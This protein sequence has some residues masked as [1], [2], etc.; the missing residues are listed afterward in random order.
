MKIG[1]LTQ[2]INNNY[3]GILQNYALQT[4]LTRMGHEVETLNWDAYRC[5]HADESKG[6]LAWQVIKT[7]ISKSI[8]RRHRN[9]PWQ[10]R[11][12]FY[13]LSAN[14][15]AFCKQYIRQSEWLWGKGQFRDHTIDGH[16]DAL[17]VG[18]DQTW[19]PQYN[20]NGMLYRMFLDFTQGLDIKRIAYA[21][22]FGVDEWEYDEEQ[23]C[24]CSNLLK[25]FHAVSVR[26][27]SGV[28][29]CRQ[30]LHHNQTECVIDPTM[31]LN[32]AD[33][34]QLLPRQRQ[35][36]S[37]GLM[38]TYILDNSSEKQYAIHNIVEKKHLKVVKFAP[39]YCNLG[40]VTDDTIGNYVSPSVIEWL[41][42]IHDADYV[43]C[44]SFHGTVF[45]IIFNKPFI[46]IGNRNRG[47]SRF[48]SLLTQF[49]LED[50]LA[51]PSNDIL[52]TLDKPF[53][54]PMVNACRQAL[55]KRS[56]QFL[57]SALSQ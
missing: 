25:N 57:S 20:R 39:M 43:I 8:L 1:I 45:S 17:L 56:L 49:G 53:D 19:R 6:R 48:L 16:F 41:Q 54:W 18:S 37:T 14:N 13:R 33:Y 31:L 2:S 44:D 46:A 15:R 24:R 34:E 4:V 29:L 9:Y 27:Q 5:D 30:Y 40:I 42:A 3:G 52:S 50:R 35:K 7:F 55:M 10:Q 26:E 22:S 12:Y 21:A 38:M 23:T 47:Y 11:E 36:S 32:P 51:E 28:Q